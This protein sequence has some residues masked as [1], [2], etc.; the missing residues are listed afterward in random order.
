[1][2]RFPSGWAGVWN[3]KRGEHRPAK[4]SE[5]DNRSKDFFEK[6]PWRAE[7]DW[8]RAIRLITKEVSATT[9]PTGLLGPAWRLLLRRGCLNAPNAGSRLRCPHQESC[10]KAYE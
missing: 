3:V 2:I 5:A 10:Y 4:I 1:M 7:G 6:N 8:T 9:E